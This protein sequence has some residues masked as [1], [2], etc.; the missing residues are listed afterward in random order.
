MAKKHCTTGEAVGVALGMRA[1]NLILTHFSQRYQKIPVLSSV[2][3]PEHVSAEELL[4]DDDAEMTAGVPN[5]LSAHQEASG[6]SEKSDTAAW[7]DGDVTRNLNIGVA[8][9]LMRVKVSQIAS[10]KKLFPAISRMFEVEQMKRDKE[11]REVSAALKAIEERKNAEKIARQEVHRR[12]FEESQTKKKKA[13]KQQSQSQ[14]AAK[15][16]PQKGSKRKLGQEKEKDADTG[17]VDQSTTSNG[18]VVVPRDEEG[19][20]TSRAQRQPH[21]QDQAG[22]NN[23]THL[24]LDENAKRA[25]KC[26]VGNVSTTEG[27]GSSL[28]EK[29]TTTTTSPEAMKNKKKRKLDSP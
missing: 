24:K 5:E 1:K 19:M 4:D 23:D 22:E 26:D 14:K 18:S 28:D 20:S 2:K 3:M 15:D 12:R 10:M 9:D 11:R 16:Q 25:Q 6:M 27:G 21:A 7:L 29:M 8:F 17:S 13:Q